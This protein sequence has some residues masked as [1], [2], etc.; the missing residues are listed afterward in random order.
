MIKALI[1]IRLKQ[2]YREITGIGVIR[3]IFLIGLIP[4]LGFA[5][6]RLTA[7][8]P[9]ANY[10]TGAFLFIVASLHIKRQDKIFLKTHFN[11]FKFVYLTEYAIISFLVIPL[12]V[13]FVIF[14]I[15]KWYIPVFEYLIFSSLHIY[16]ITI[17]YAFYEPDKKSA[18]AQI[19]GA[20]GVL[21]C[22]IPILL[23]VVWVLGIRFYFKSCKNLNFY[24]ND[25]N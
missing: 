11:N 21:G 2:L 22:L 10:I 18:A 19:F 23:P 15:E 12:I 14:H 1:L 24:L 20:F 17:K 5:L 6:F 8:L 25:Y 16:I 9:Y 13:S 4:I 7:K 3:I